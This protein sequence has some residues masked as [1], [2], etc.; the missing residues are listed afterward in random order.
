MCP[1]RCARCV[2][3]VLELTH[4]TPGYRLVCGTGT[5]GTQAV[6]DR[7]QR[8]SGAAAGLGGAAYG[9]G[10]VGP[11]TAGRTPTQ[12]RQLITNLTDGVVAAGVAP[13]E[14][15]RVVVREIPPEHFAAGDVTI[16]ERHGAPDPRAGAGAGEGEGA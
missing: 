14:A 10:S 15:V 6:W 3:W 11:G 13:R 2:R 8:Q 4:S 7:A 5:R 9:S 12:V 1:L 16:A